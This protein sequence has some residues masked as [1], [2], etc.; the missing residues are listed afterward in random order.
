MWHDDTTYSYELY[1]HGIKGQ[2]WGVRRFQKKDGSLTSAGKKRYSDS[3]RKSKHQ[4]KL[5]EKYKSQGMS[6]QEAEIEAKKRIRTER[7]LVAAGTATIAAAAAYVVHK[8]LKIKGDGM[9]KAGGLLRRVEVKGDGVL[10]D[11]F[12]AVDKKSDGH[13][14]VGKLGVQRKVEE[15]KAYLMKINV[16]KDIKVAGRDKAIDVYTKLFNNDKEFREAAILLSTKNVHGG[17]QI[18]LDAKDKKR[19][20]DMYENFNTHFTRHGNPAVKKFYA[21]LKEEG[22]GAVRDVNDMKFSGY[23]AKNPL[24]IFDH[25]NKLSVASVRELYGREVLKKYVQDG[26]KEAAV[27]MG[28]VG[29]AT[30][31]A[32]TLYTAGEMYIEDRRDIT[33]K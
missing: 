12:Y 8:N 18:N 19:I 15:G 3:P 4:A 20:R 17:N 6:Q 22:Y 9:I 5:E 24:I 2:K 32:G 29:A 16:Q 26:A 21:A 33:K 30:V 23:N 7:L 31:A 27:S 1:H 14:Y 28:K 11:T 13:K 10:H 25:T